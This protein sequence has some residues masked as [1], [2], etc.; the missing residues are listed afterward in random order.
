VSERTT[1]IRSV[2]SM[3]AAY[4]FTQNAIGAEKA[5]RIVAADYIRATPG[6]RVFDIGSGTSDI[7]EHLP[8]VEYFGLEPSESYV[9]AARSRFGRRVTIV[10]GGVDDFDPAPWESSCDVVVSVGVLHHLTDEQAETLLTSAATLLRPAG[11]FIAIDPCLQQGQSRIA[12]ALIVRDRG[13]NVRTQ[14]GSE[15]L[16][17]GIFKTSRVTVRHDLLRFPYTH[18]IIEATA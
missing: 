17:H 10:H 9:A 15:D 4:R 7:L 8:A 14:A 5:R 13:Q 12:R 1:G 6:S 2:L 3:A 11:R 18:S 16:I